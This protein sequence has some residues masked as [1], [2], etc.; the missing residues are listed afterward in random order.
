MGFLKRLFHGPDPF[1]KPCGCG[2]DS[3]VRVAPEPKFD[4]STGEMYCL[5]CLEPLVKAA[6]SALEQPWVIV[7]PYRHAPCMVPFAIEDLPDLTNWPTGVQELL[8]DPARACAQ[9][10]APTPRLLWIATDP[11]QSLEDMQDQSH[12][13]DD[14]QGVYL[15]GGCASKEMLDTLQQRE[16]KIEEMVM[17]SGGPG[18]WLPWAY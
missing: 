17:P 5:T 2:R 4:F 3:R 9:C 14:K 16:I 1:E 8:A 7:Q 12:W 10:G 18:V 13:F 6:L 15:C 11:G